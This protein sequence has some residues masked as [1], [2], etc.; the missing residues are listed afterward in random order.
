M[1]GSVPDSGVRRHLPR[2]LRQRSSAIAARI[3]ENSLPLDEMPDHL[4]KAVLA[5]EDR[6][7]FDHFGIDVIG[8][9]AP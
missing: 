2:P 6:R 9:F 4:V 3:H 8:L 5:T 7:F 1:H